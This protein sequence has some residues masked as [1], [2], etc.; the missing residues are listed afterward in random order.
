[1]GKDRKVEA[2]LKQTRILEEE[3]KTRLKEQNTLFNTEN[4]GFIEVET[5]RERTLKVS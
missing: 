4:R 2:T 3:T 1:M 5:E